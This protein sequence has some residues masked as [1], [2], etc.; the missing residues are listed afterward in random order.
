MKYIKE[1]R[2]S[3]TK[4]GEQLFIDD[5][6]EQKEQ[7]KGGAGIDKGKRENREGKA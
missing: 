1:E 2:N 4:E 6:E 7:K 5:R 3:G